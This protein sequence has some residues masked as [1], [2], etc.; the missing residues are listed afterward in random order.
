MKWLCFLWKVGCREKEGRR[1]ISRGG[2]KL[3]LRREEEEL[4]QRNGGGLTGHLAAWML[5]SRN[6]EKSVSAGSAIEREHGGA[7]R[8]LLNLGGYPFLGHLFQVFSEE[9]NLSPTDLQL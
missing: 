4:T 3:S 7:L 1:G 2:L 9:L 8:I 5:E 6:S